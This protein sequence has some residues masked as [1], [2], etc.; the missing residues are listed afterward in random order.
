M[1]RHLCSDSGVGLLSWRDSGPGWKSWL[2]GGFRLD[3]GERYECGQGARGEVRR[4]V[5]AWTES[6]ENEHAV[7]RGHQPIARVNAGDS[8][9]CRFNAN[10]GAGIRDRVRETGDAD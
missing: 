8:I 2:G 5:A 3:S 7:I 1:G 10:D 6:R 4:S 9:A